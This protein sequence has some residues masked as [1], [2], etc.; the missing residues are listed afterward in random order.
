MSRCVICT[1]CYLLGWRMPLCS[2]L[3][4]V[5][6]N[7]LFLT[8]SEV[9]WFSV[10]VLG[11]SAPA[12]LGYL[13]DRCGGGASEAE[14]QKRR[15]HAVHRKDLQNVQLTRQDAM[16]EVKDLLKQLDDLLSHACLS[17]ESVY[18]LL[19][20]E[21]HSESS[22]SVTLSVC[23]LG[24]TL[25]PPDQQHCVCVLVLQDSNSTPLH[26]PFSSPPPPILPPPPLQE[27][28]DISSDLD[29]ISITS[30]N[31]LLSRNE[32]IR[33]KVSKLTEK[34]RKRYPTNNT[35]QS[36]LRPSVHLLLPHLNPT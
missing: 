27:D 8:L 18:K 7:I 28:D 16:L 26:S 17:A 1:A 13:Q 21:S 22:R 25:S 10:C 32:P 34:L 5:L 9:G 4:C 12:A 35:G 31:G 30:D 3:V 20:W 24:A 19:Y 36:T 15:C 33:S 6:L 14:Q 2:L 11:V 23:V 29:T